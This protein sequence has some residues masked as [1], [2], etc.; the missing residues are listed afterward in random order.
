MRPCHLALL[1]AVAALTVSCS[2]LPLPVGHAPAP[3][4]SAGKR[5]DLTPDERLLAAEE[6]V[7]AGEYED[8]QWI[9]SPLV[10]N[11]TQDKRVA[12]LSRRIAASL[13]DNREAAATEMRLVQDTETV[14]RR[15]L[16][17]AASHRLGDV[18]RLIR[19]G[20][21][22]E[23]QEALTPLI[24]KKLFAEEVQ[25]L[26]AEI[27][28]ARAE[29]ARTSAEVETRRRGMEEVQQRLVLPSTY[30]ATVVISRETA[31][32]ALPPGPME[33]LISRKV[34]MNLQDA[35]VKELVDVLTKVDGLN[36][37]ADDA[38]TEEKRLTISVTDVPLRELLSYIARNMGI[39]FH[40][41]ENTVWVTESMD[42]PGSGPELETRIFKLRRGFAP[43]LQGG[44]GGED[45]GGLGGGG[46]DNDLEDVLEAFLSNSPD[47][48][49]YRIFKNRNLL[50][51]KDS[52]ENI[53]LVEELV[54]EFDTTP[55]QVLIEARFLTI[56]QDDLKELGFD[57]PEFSMQGR[58]VDSE[59]QIMT[60]DASST[61]E[62]FKNVA[63]G[64]NMTLTGILGNY[65]Y[66]AVL[67][68]L[69]SSG[70]TQTL[71]APRVTV[72]NNQTARIRKGDKLYYFEQYDT[73]TVDRGD[74]SGTENVLVP[75]GSPTEL[76]LGITLN[77]K[78]NVGNDGRTIN[79]AL[80]PEVIQF[81]KWI[82]FLTA[83][84]QTGGGDG[85]N[86]GDPG[87]P[88]G[89]VSLPQIN[90][91][92]VSTTVV[93]N[94]GETVVLGG[95]IETKRNQTIHK[96]PLLGDIPVLGYLFKHTEET[97]EPQHLLI[98]VTASV[99]NPR[100]EFVR[101]EE[102]EPGN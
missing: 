27:N 17:K 34:T 8:A 60:M 99:V 94:S 6:L 33:E 48:A 50:V 38:L 32:L 40:L 51:V 92:M 49:T 65:T 83:G 79:L 77:V 97:E 96:V 66:E 29:A 18:K 37:I 89:R 13:A 82:D 85:G 7:R 15:I 101:Y 70:R 21:W 74:L 28:L 25:A 30:G 5:A 75:S 80:L 47:G 44:G 11:G 91:S 54:K 22:A 69:E 100:G 58:D 64:S 71:S 78:V 59:A 55:F 88:G 1:L 16:L 67:H 68:A 84:D 9:L 87:Q 12:E 43:Q 46:G 14:E 36:V 76:D 41:G 98:F 72:L 19:D 61:F 23:A 57:I 102:T 86:N 24:G 81:I 63:N 52:L 93:V 39:A 45:G 90:E 31:P 20:R 26:A 35:G 3:G 56:A 2:H 62:A 73:E 42:P 53:R 10:G 95:M 4:T